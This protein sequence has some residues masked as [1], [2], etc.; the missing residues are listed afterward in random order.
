MSG[1]L[2]SGTVVDRSRVNDWLLVFTKENEK[3]LGIKN[4]TIWPPNGSRI[5]AETN[6]G[7]SWEFAT[8]RE[9]SV[10]PSP[11]PPY[12]LQKRIP[13]TAEILSPLVLDW[14]RWHRTCSGDDIYEKA[15]EL[16]PNR[17]PRVIG[18]AFSLLSRQG[19]IRRVGIARSK[20][21]ECHHYPNMSVWELVVSHPHDDRSGQN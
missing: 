21:P 12:D 9:I 11:S 8:S 17:D 7:R 5:S 1:S 2:Y 20:R 18:S 15:R 19:K 4:G 10:D 6:A 16:L 13:G 3:P 14:L